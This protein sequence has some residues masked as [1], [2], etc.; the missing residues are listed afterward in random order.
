MDVVFCWTGVTPTMVA[1]WRAFA[2]LPG[3]RLKLLIELPSRTDT[4]FDEGRVLAGLDHTLRAADEPL[5]RHGLEREIAAFS[6]DVIAVLGWR[7]PMCRAVAE[8]PVFRSVPKIFAFDMPFRW[9][10][11]KLLAPLVL[12]R[13]LCRFERAFVTGAR[14]AAYARHLG[15][16]PGLIETGLFAMDTGAWH[17]AR[18]ARPEVERYPRRFLYVGRYA[19]EKRI[20]LLAAAYERYRGRVAEPW[21][22]TCAGMGPEKGRLAGHEGVTD[23]GFVQPDELPRLFARHSCFVI[24]SDYDPWPMVIAEALASGMP[25]V[26]TAACGSHVELVQPFG[27]G[28]VC[29][30]GDV[31][32]LARALE[33]IHTH[34]ADIPA[35]ASRCTA[36]VE[37]YSAAAWAARFRSLCEQVIR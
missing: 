35:L 37:P 10:L 7:G 16:R 22:L 30:T 1:G 36:A 27:N 29:R 28:V 18:A 23:V 21:G 8:S 26:C 17:D 32:G 19:R 33:W 5:D 13:Y 24:A 11:R 4:A 3:V 34:A 25:V 31:E 20:D 15:F 2:A 6:P 9:T 14:A 12:R